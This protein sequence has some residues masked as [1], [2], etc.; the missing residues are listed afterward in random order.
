MPAY[1]AYVKDDSG[2]T[3]ERNATPPMPGEVLKG[4]FKKKYFL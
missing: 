2:V 4:W 3:V 1:Y